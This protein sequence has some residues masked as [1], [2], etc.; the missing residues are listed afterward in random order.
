MR[1]SR[2]IRWPR[3][4]TG[5]RD[6]L[7]GIST[8]MLQLPTAL[9][10]NSDDHSPMVHVLPWFIAEPIRFIVVGVWS[11]LMGAAA[12]G[13]GLWHAVMGESLGANALLLVLGLLL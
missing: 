1:S 13:V 9:S 8:Q 7:L 10:E 11:Q 5:I 4:G 6:A 2:P 3:A 12:F